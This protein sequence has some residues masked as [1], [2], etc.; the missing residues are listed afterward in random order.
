MWCRNL[1]TSW[2]GV[3]PVYEVSEPT[4][5]GMLGRVQ[6]VNAVLEPTSLAGVQPVYALSTIGSNFHILAHA[7]VDKRGGTGYCST[8]I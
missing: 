6:P 2:A 5:W 4:T 1:A 3:Q 7:R 8:L